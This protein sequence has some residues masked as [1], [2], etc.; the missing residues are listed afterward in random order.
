MELTSRGNGTDVRWLSSFE[1]PVPLLGR[2]L[3]LIIKRT[4]GKVHQSTLEQAK[5]ILE[6]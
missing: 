1:V 4:V 2:V 5:V 6:A 3:E